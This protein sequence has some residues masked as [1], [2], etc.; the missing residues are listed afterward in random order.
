MTVTKNLL[1]AVVT[2]GE[3]AAEKPRACGVDTGNKSRANTSVYQT[4]LQASA[5]L[6]LSTVPDHIETEEVAR[7]IGHWKDSLSRC[8]LW[9]I[10]KPFS[11]HTQPQHTSRPRRRPNRR[12]RIRN[13]NPIRL[14]YPV[15]PPLRITR[16]I[17]PP[18]LT[19]LMHS[20][21]HRPSPV[22]AQELFSRHFVDF[23][24]VFVAHEGRAADGEG[25]EDG[26]EAGAVA[27]DGGDGADCTTD[28]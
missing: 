16:R 7:L 20:T 1:M 8:S 19:K 21:L 10:Y 15:S 22:L 14:P 6:T 2:T 23:F 26:G 27:E 25:R 13:I 18:P 5:D 17:D 9:Y 3:N 11:L 4:R 12:F 24:A 28:I